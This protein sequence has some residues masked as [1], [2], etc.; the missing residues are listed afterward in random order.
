MFLQFMCVCVTASQGHR[1]TVCVLSYSVSLHPHHGLP[2][3]RCYLLLLHLLSLFF[4]LLEPPPNNTRVFTLII[5]AL[6]S[7]LLFVLGVYTPGKYDQ[8]QL[9]AYQNS[10]LRH[11]NRTLNFLNESNLAQ[12]TPNAALDANISTIYNKTDK[13]MNSS[14][15]L[16]QDDVI[17]NFR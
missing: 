15:W 8:D 2:F 6:I 11:N 10:M 3:D 17:G 7:G 13:M 5:T 12:P 16:M 1:L 9:L 4:H 14:K